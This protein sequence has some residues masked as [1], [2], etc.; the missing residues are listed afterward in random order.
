M[1]T[2]KKIFITGGAGFIA[3]MLISKLADQN[4]IVVYDNYT[5]N[6]LKDT[7]YS[8]HPNVKQVH[9][10][11]LDFSKLKE[12][13]TGS[14]IVVHA[15]AI[16]GIDSTVRNPVSTMRVNMIGAANAMEAAHQLGKIER[17]IDFSTSEVFG[18][19]A[20]KV[21]ENQQTVTGAVG[22][23]RWTYAVSKLAGEHLAHAYH[24]QYEMP[25]V[26]VRP[27][28]VYGPG[29]TGEG[30][31]SIFVRRAL[32]NEDIL[33]FGDGSQ[34][35]A[36]LYVDDMVE[37]VLCALEH[38]NAIGE[39]FNI[40]NSRAVT[41]IYGLAQT[42]C[43]IT[44]SSSKIIFRDALS[45]DIELRIPSVGKAKEL[46]GFEAKVDLDLGLEKTAA[47]IAANE[48]SLPPLPKLFKS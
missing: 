11:V 31:L 2:G 13:M 19:Y 43:R 44:N 23:A 7:P 10:D 47:W 27:F 8:N 45:A 9:G 34:I 18:S 32:K 46:I 12:A 36:W 38:P 16:A 6:T 48:K 37:G 26:T 40:G 41:T 17:F 1:I 29:Q 5:R 21:D 39:S 14:Q 15:A 22:E 35:R 42:I 20:F 28:N 25:T 3:S 33:I 4:D 24:K 30:A